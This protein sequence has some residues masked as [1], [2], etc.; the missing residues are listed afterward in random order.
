M[1]TAAQLEAVVLNPDGA[2]RFAVLLV[3]EGV[4][5]G[6]DG[7]LHT[8]ERD[9]DGPV[10]T[11]D[12]SNLV[13]DRAT[14]GVCESPVRGVV[15]AEVVR[16]DE[17]TGLACPIPDDVAQ[18]SMDEVRP[19]VIAHRMGAPVS[20]HL[21][22]DKVAHRKTSTQVAL[23]DD[24]TGNRFLR[25]VDREQNG[26][27]GVPEYAPIPNLS[28]TLGVERRLIQ[29][30]LRRCGRLR[31]EFF[32]AL[33]FERLVFDAVPEDRHDPGALMARGLV[34]DEHCVTGTPLN[35]LI[36]RGQLR[37]P[38]EIGLG[39]GSRPI[40]LLGEGRVEAGPVH[41]DAV[42]GGELDRQVDREP[43]CVVEFERAIAVQDGRIDGQ[44]FGSTAH[45]RLQ[46]IR[47]A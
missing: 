25:V 7:F 2:H 24:Q 18:G 6:V 4:R 42:L 26:L 37:V 31:S 45:D 40:S 23:M 44:I 1:R 35:R 11:D 43:E 34:A 14:L 13:L 20:V 28:T 30:H 47:P 5:A 27:V 39:A 36:L 19:G 38:C 29:D 15:E 33:C 3:E 16:G 46:N 12:A 21:G 41:A 9:R 22:D 10:L 32:V 17:R 8:H